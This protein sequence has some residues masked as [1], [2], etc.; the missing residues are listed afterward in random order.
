VERLLG[1]LI[2]RK[3]SLWG[4]SVSGRLVQYQHTLLRIFNVQTRRFCI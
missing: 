4:R 1:V 2:I 3:W